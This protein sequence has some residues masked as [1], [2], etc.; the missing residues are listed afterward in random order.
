MPP[1]DAFFDSELSPPP[2]RQVFLWLC[3]E[4][5]QRFGPFAW[6]RFNDDPRTIIDQD[7]QVVASWVDG[8]WRTSDSGCAWSNPTIGPGPKHPH[9]N[10]G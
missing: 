1:P 2:N 10:R 3:C 7:G 6:L 8:H 9:P 4:G 5:W